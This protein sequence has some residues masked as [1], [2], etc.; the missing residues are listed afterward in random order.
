MNRAEEAGFIKF[1][2]SKAHKQIKPEVR[3]RKS[4]NESIIM[5]GCYQY[6]KLLLRLRTSDLKLPSFSYF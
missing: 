1:I 6:R 4:E 5:K 2:F 3:G